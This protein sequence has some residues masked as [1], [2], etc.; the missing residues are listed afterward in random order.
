[1][2]AVM[3]YLPPKSLQ[4]GFKAHCNKWDTMAARKVVNQSEVTAVCFGK[5]PIM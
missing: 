1:M 3:N 2:F 4:V 5:C